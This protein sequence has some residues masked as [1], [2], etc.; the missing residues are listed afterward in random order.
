MN[1]EIFK[2]DF[3]MKIKHITSKILSMFILGAMVFTTSCDDDINIQRDIDESDYNGIYTNNVYLRDAKT[4]KRSNIV[5]LYHDSD[6]KKIK[7]GLSKA[8]TA[9]TSATV[10]ID[11][12]Y[13]AAY[14]LEHETD[15]ELYPIKDITLSND[16]KFVGVDGAK[17][18]ELDMMIKSS[19]GLVQDKTYAIPLTITEPSSDIALPNED[20]KHSIYLVK[21]MRSLSDAYKGPDAVQGFLFIETNN[22]NPLNALAFELENGKLVWDYMTIFAANI[23]YD[24]EAGRPYLQPNP[25]VQFLLA[26]H[27]LYLQPLRKRGIKVI[28]G[29]LGNH[30]QAGL[31]QL[32]EQGSKDF[33]RELAQY[34]YTYNLDGVNFDDEYS[35]SPD[36]NN[37]ALTQRSRQAAARLMF[38][39][40]KK[41]PDKL[42]TVY[43]YG[44]MYGVDEVDGV[45]IKEWVDI[46]VPDY[47][48]TPSPIGELT[49]KNLS[50]QSMEFVRGGGG[51]LDANKILNGGYGYYMGFS[52]NPRRFASAKNRMAAGIEKIYGSPLADVK[53]FYKNQDTTVYDYEKDKAEIP[54]ID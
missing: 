28:L 2:Q 4:N 31:A 39:T 40:K 46:V 15:F 13:L 26:N 52:L 33:A 42:V 27:E 14:N 11:A 16:G 30:D 44:S 41:M 36:P 5:E 10:K 35:S 38:E 7:L 9:S 47:G 43:D 18:I 21:D 24:G 20:A 12:E 23:N 53:I 29:L 8:A 17:S 25:E 37:P 22:V 48:A 34:C 45:D 51:Y 1:C 6:T 3:I 49:N 32:S 54:Q 50:G 19:S